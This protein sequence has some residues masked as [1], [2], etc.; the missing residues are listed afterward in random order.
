MLTYKLKIKSCNNPE[1]ISKMQ[2]DY[3]YAFRKL[4]CNFDKINNKQF[5]NEIC[6]K[7]FLDSWQFESLKTEVK[8]KMLKIDFLRNKNL[9]LQEEI[10]QDLKLLKEKN[11]KK[12]KRKIFKLQNK[13]NKLKDF[14]DI[15]FGTKVLLKQLSALSNNKEKNFKEI[16][17]LKQEY[18]NRRISPIFIGGET[19]HNGNRKFNFQLENNKLI[20]KP[21]CKTKIDIEFISSKKQHIVLLQLQKIICQNNILP[22]TVR[23]STEFVWISFD[24]EILNGYGLNEKEMKNELKNISKDN[25]YKRKE[26]IKKFYTEQ[27]SRKILGKIKN[28]YLA[29]DL[30]PNYIG[31]SICDKIGRN[32]KIIKKGC[33]AFSELSVKLGLESKNKRQVKQNNKRKYEICNLIK[34]LFFK[35]TYYKVAYFCIEDLNFKN[36]II[37]EFNKEFNRK[38]RN[39]WHRVLTC[40]LINKYC[41]CLGIQ[42]IEVNPVYT[43][44]IGNIKYKY[45]DPINA[46]LEI[47][48]RG[49]NKFE[50]DTFFPKITEDDFDTM[51]NLIKNNQMRDVQNKTELLRKLKSLITWKDFFNLFKHTGL[52]Y[53]RSLDDL[54][55]SFRR[56]RLFS[57]KSKV[58]LYEL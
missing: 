20:F 19:Y 6:Q 53:R 32:I 57:F 46:S 50:K 12:S 29:I 37:N 31:W 33:Y 14:R 43:S 25:N 40:N 41:N 27:K 54:K 38:V 26:I 42:K 36:I 56:F 2:Q 28:R 30:N 17:S 35:A 51:S 13:L 8:T 18:K 48:R 49:M 5:I 55:E 52:K 15:V 21:V 9:K 4:Y 1:L 39:I 34:D 58:L 23:I 22:V 10:K 24:E 3:S 16:K 45:F 7:Y 47:C 44:F 11:N